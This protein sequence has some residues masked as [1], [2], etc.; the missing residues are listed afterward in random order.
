[1]AQRRLDLYRVLDHDEGNGPPAQHR[2]AVTDKMVKT[3]VLHDTPALFVL[4]P[5]SVKSGRIA[6]ERWRC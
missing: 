5:K 1:M 2:F 4:C 6:R 3:A